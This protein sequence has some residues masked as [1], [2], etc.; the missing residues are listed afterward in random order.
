MAEH[1]IEWGERSVPYSNRNERDD[2]DYMEWCLSSGLEWLHK[3]VT[4]NTYGERYEMFLPCLSTN[5]DFIGSMLFRT[6][7]LPLPAL[8]PFDAFDGRNLA[9]LDEEDQSKIM[10][11]SF[12]NDPDKGP[13][14]AWR[15]AY[16]KSDVAKLYYGVEQEQLRERGYVMFDFDRLSRWNVFSAPFDAEEAFD[17]W[18]KRRR[19][20][21]D[22]PYERMTRSWDERSKIWLRG[23]RGWWSDGDESKLI[24]IYPK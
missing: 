6:T 1:D 24:W 22:E 21:D 18:Y 20:E 15:W 4:A 14:K 23:G 17:D 19:E 16:Q 9:E 7:S 5:C 8:G 2:N 3:L 12:A 11:T 10:S 13:S